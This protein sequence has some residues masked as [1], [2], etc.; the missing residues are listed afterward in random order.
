[1]IYVTLKL[2]RTNICK[3]NKTL[4]MSLLM[5]PKKIKKKITLAWYYIVC[6]VEFIFKYKI[7]KCKR[8]HEYLYFKGFIKKTERMK[9]NVV[10]E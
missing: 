8:K 4:Q 1:M 3:V 5:V 7:F 10:I 9:K 2:I 6:K